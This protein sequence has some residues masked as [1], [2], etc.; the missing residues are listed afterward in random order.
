VKILGG[1]LLSALLTAALAYATILPPT[2]SSPV[3]ASAFT[4]PVTA[5]FLADTG[6][7]PFMATN[8]LG[9]TTITGDYRASVYADPDNTLCA[10]CLDFF[11]WVTSHSTSTDAIERITDAAF[12]VFETDVGYSVGPGSVA[13]GVDPDTVDRSSDGNV[14]GFNFSEPVGVPPGSSTQVLEIETNATTF[15]AGSLQI[16]DSSVAS[17]PAF[18]PG[19]T[20]PEASSITLTLLGGALLGIGYIRRR[21]RRAA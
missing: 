9:Q 14:I 11:I 2:G 19:A 3:P 4:T 13:D 15:V 20:V 6:V 16:I 10:G 18:A 12:G 17:V 1:S 21:R 7:Q 5:P 8:S